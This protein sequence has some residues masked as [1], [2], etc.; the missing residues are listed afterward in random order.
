MNTKN[1]R[2]NDTVVKNNVFLNNR[3]GLDIDPADEKS[4]SVD[5]NAYIDNETDLRFRNKFVSYTNDTSRINKWDTH[6]II[7]QK[8][9]FIDFDRKN[10]NIPYQ[11]PLRGRGESVIPFFTIRTVLNILGLGT[12]IGP[13]KFQWWGNDCPLLD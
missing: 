6:S 5:Y 11:S 3:I 7:A 2:H 8:S 12:D 9:A 1:T 13:C 4:V 10:F